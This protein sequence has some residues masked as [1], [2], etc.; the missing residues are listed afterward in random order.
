MK[1]VN[2][3]QNKTTRRFKYWLARINGLNSKLSAKLRDFTPSKHQQYINKEYY[4]NTTQEQNH[5]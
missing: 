4:K 3:I 1:Y 2:S 5:Q